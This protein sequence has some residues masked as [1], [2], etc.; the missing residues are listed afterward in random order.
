MT[1]SSPVTSLFRAVSIK[2][3]PLLF[4]SQ[5]PLNLPLSSAVLEEKNRGIAP[6]IYHLSV[7]PDLLIYF[8]IQNN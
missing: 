3:T 4:H 7:S 6:H 8:S 2:V 1:A 5:G